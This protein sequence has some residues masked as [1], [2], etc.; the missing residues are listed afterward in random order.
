MIEVGGRYLN[1][2]ACLPLI[3]AEFRSMKAVKRL[4]LM[5]HS[6]TPSLE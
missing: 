1:G 5:H 2:T 4:G 6:L 3:K